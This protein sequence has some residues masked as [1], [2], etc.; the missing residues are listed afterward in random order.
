M[1]SAKF[2]ENTNFDEYFSN[3]VEIIQATS[4]DFIY[5]LL[6]NRYHQHRIRNLGL[7]IAKC[8]LCCIWHYLFKFTSLFNHKM[9]IVARRKLKISQSQDIMFID[10]SLQRENLPKRT[11]MEYAKWLTMECSSAERGTLLNFRG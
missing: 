2:F 3:Q 11:I 9:Q 8:K 1:E 10:L 5:T 7:H 4:Y 6:Q